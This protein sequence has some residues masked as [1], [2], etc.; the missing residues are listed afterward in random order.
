MDL[1]TF[2]KYNLQHDY[3]V[4]C[5]CGLIKIFS[6]MTNKKMMAV[7]VLSVLT[8]TASVYSME[9]T[10]GIPPQYCKDA[11]KI[12]V[13]GD[14]NNG[15]A[16]FCSL[17]SAIDYIKSKPEYNW[18]IQVNYS[19]S[20][21]SQ[22][23]A[24]V[25]VPCLIICG[26]GQ[27][28]QIFVNHMLINSQGFLR[29]VNIHFI[30]YVNHLLQFDGKYIQLSSI[31]SSK[32]LWFINANNL[33]INN[34][35]FSYN[36]SYS[37][38]TLNFQA[39]YNCLLSNVTL[40]NSLL[41]LNIL[42]SQQ[43]FTSVHII[44]CRIL[45]TIT[46]NYLLT[47]VIV[48]NGAKELTVVSSEFIGQNGSTFAYVIYI[49]SNV[50]KVNISNVTIQKYNVTSS[51]I[52][53]MNYNEY[54]YNVT[55]ANIENSLF[56][57][58]SGTVITYT[59]C[60]SNC[61]LVLTNNTFTQSQGTMVRANSIGDL[62][63]SNNTV[64]FVTNQIFTNT[65]LVYIQNCNV[66]FSMHNVFTNNI[67]T[68]LKLTEPFQITFD[69]N[70]SL[71][72]HNNVGKHGGGMGIICIKDCLINLLSSK[73]NFTNNLAILGGA[74]YINTNNVD[75][76]CNLSQ[77]VTF[78]DNQAITEGNDILVEYNGPNYN[79]SCGLSHYIVVIHYSEMNL[80]SINNQNSITLFPGEY[81]RFKASSSA[82]CE[83]ILYLKCKGSVIFCQINKIK[84]NGSETIVIPRGNLSIIHSNLQLRAP[85]ESFTN[86]NLSVS[87][88]NYTSTIP[89]NIRPCPL[90]YT[91]SKTNMTC[92]PCS[93]C[94][95]E[96][97]VS[98]VTP[99]QSVVCL[100]H[101][102]WYGEG[103]LIHLCDYPYC[104][105]IN[106]RKECPIAGNKNYFKLPDAVD[107]QC[108]GDRSGTLCRGCKDGYTFTY[109]AVQC[110]E[111]KGTQC[112]GWL[113]G[114]VLVSIVIN[115]TVGIL[116][117]VILIKWKGGVA[118]G[119]T[120]GPVFFLSNVRVLSFGVQPI[121]IIVSIFSLLI[122]DN[123][124]L[125]YI[126]VCTP[127]QSALVYQ[128]FNYIGPLILAVMVGMIYLMANCYSKYNVRLVSPIHAICLLVFV[129]FWSLASSS[130]DIV[131]PV[132]LNNDAR[133]SIEPDIPYLHSSVPWYAIILWIIAVIIL[134]AMVTLIMLIFITPLLSKWFNMNRI[135]TFLD[136]Y[137]SCYKDKWHWYCSVYLIVSVIISIT[138]KTLPVIDFVIT[139]NTIIFLLLLLHIA[140]QPYKSYLSCFIDS[141]LLIDLLILVNFNA[142][143][144]YNTNTVYKVGM[145][146]LTFLP[147]LYI[148]VMIIVALVY[149]C[150]P[151]R[152]G[153]WLLNIF[154][155]N[156]KSSH[157]SSLN[158]SIEDN[159]V[160]DHSTVVPSTEISVL[161]E[162][163]Y[164]DE[165]EL[166]SYDTFDT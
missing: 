52:C 163:R 13:Q 65:E 102:Y 128:Y 86:I 4:I 143:E 157:H 101:G 144:T 164:K 74:V 32:E 120:L 76:I 136:F 16:S 161:I 129:T 36:S 17:T 29:L 95:S 28:H 98:S 9:C 71:K 137:Q 45:N 123:S 91:Y 112:V 122:L 10:T 33:S 72:F 56:S 67:G 97:Y 151:R 85:N 69:E 54:E 142:A 43:L 11:H 51:I 162:D 90:S 62:Q 132:I 100:K 26:I 145:H 93:D 25:N 44:D 49:Q 118:L 133:F 14:C 106:D 113:I 87:C 40:V 61:S 73:V 84:V 63:L 135:K 121:D 140:T 5:G 46:E 18:I 160:E 2:A 15:N 152:Y 108:N 156:I 153:L 155:R 79:N 104:R 77:S 1:I 59:Q 50:I 22:V 89:I 78:I 35:I 94:N 27:H 103:N 146:L 114:L 148:F 42:H 99:Y 119:L 58:N 159:R 150:I 111:D 124:I 127:I 30:G 68:A 8:T 7:F 139:Y 83:S 70:S 57:W 131:S 21:T 166:Y 82:T 134:V 147:F 105:H 109:L 24:T 92:V 48:V 55:Y 81:I 47:P 23:S 158:T 3:K 20:I 41:S 138:N 141:F 154:K 38:A 117:I 96:L 34:S 19:H 116:W 75:L 110:V 66:M 165:V 80:T 37:S 115:I 60:S 64:S 12:T 107:E 6:S 53:F 39:S 149:K 125:G 31:S 88:L 126:P 130:I